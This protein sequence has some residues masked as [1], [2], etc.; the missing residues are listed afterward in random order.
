MRRVLAIVLLVLCAAGC[1]PAP[2][3]LV[4]RAPARLLQGETSAD[5][6]LCGRLDVDL[7]FDRTDDLGPPP[8]E[9]LALVPSGVACTWEL[10][11]QVELPAGTY[12]L[13]VRFLAVRNF[14]GQ[15]TCGDDEV[16]VGAYVR[17]DIDFPDGLSALEESEFL[18]RPGE[19]SELGVSGVSF[20]PDGDARDTLAEV[21]QGANPCEPSSLPSVSVDPLD[22]TGTEGT[23]IQW[24]LSSSDED[25]VPHWVTFRIEQRFGAEAGT[26]EIVLRANT[27]D[28]DAF[29]VTPDDDRRPALEGWRLRVLSATQ[30]GP[31]SATWQV[32]LEPDEPFIGTLDVRWSADDGQGNVLDEGGAATAEIENVADPTLLVFYD[33]NEEQAR[34]TLEFREVGPGVTP[35]TLQ[36]RLV[37]QDLLVDASEWTVELT[38]DEPTGMTL[39]PPSGTPYFTLDWAPDNAVALAWPL[40]GQD[41][42]LRLRDADGAEVRTETVTLEVAPLYNDAPWFTVPTV[43][44]LGLSAAAFAQHEMRFTVH[45]PDE[46][47]DA[48]SCTL[49]I[50]PSGATTCT[51]PFE[52]IT[53]GPDGTRA[54]DAWPFIIRLE[55]ATDYFTACGARPTFT[56]EI[57]ISDV[58]PTGAEPA[59]SQVTSAPTC[60]QAEAHCQQQLAL[61]TADIISWGEV[62]AGAGITPPPWG[63]SEWAVHGTLRKAVGNV[64][65]D[66]TGY[67]DVVII[68]LEKPSPTYE[69]VLP[70]DE[71]C[72][73]DNE[74][75]RGTTAV[76]EGG[77]YAVVYGWDDIAGDMS[78]SCDGDRVVAIVD[79][80][81]Y[82]VTT[83]RASD[84]C[85]T[86]SGSS[87]GCLGNPLMDD[88]GDV[89]IVCDKG[90]PDGELVRLQSD[91]T[92]TRKALPG[93][94]DFFENETNL[95]VTDDVGGRWVAIPDETQFLFVDVD[96]SADPIV[97]VV[98]SAP[99]L[100]AF[101]FEAW[102]VDPGRDAI[103]LAQDREGPGG[104]SDPGPNAELFMVSMTGGSPTL[105]GPLDIGDVGGSD[106]NGDSF[107]R[108]LLREPP[109]A[110][111][112]AITGPH[113]AV[114]GGSTQDVPFVDL[115][116]FTVLGVRNTTS[117]CQAAGCSC[118]DLYKMPD[119]RYLG[120]PGTSCDGSVGDEDGLV[121]YGWEV[122]GN[123][124]FVPAPVLDFPGS[125]DTHQED[126]ITSE[127]GSLFV[128]TDDDRPAVIYFD[129]AAAGAD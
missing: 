96:A 31:G 111:E 9:N 84:V 73:I 118:G 16:W 108:I 27:G 42:T 51:A 100:D 56:M 88:A 44:E 117:E 122:T 99:E 97:P 89:W 54:G 61:Q 18:S 36:F 10:G 15:D 4:I 105:S 109:R 50:Q 37:N 20:D 2:E 124:L 39:S 30:D 3:P 14:N 43:G 1:R 32:E 78:R 98:V 65:S 120:M 87:V 33:G 93:L 74:Y 40:T 19:E 119:R 45:D 82:G 7:T 106:N 70:A 86:C 67:E 52:T 64:D 94:S 107:M 41:L 72:E 59:T 25:E 123:T 101:E 75:W 76:H 38:G 113:L 116:T 23:P 62:G 68:D 79:L 13:L 12:D 11:E 121:L 85:T 66:G 83:V 114:A 77:D 91:G 80:V 24:T 60:G 81:T 49:D 104:S 112:P 128:I 8:V 5:A 6:E 46:V 34:D 63:V 125:S 58:A 29:T 115:D 102:A 69:Y 55:P 26:E 71:L 21:A 57:S 35:T 90:N 110:G 95:F 22:V 48:P 47:P 127:A 92:L 28:P 17:R 103:L 129:D 53:C 126:Y